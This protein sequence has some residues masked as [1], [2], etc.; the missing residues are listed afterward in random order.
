MTETSNQ[1]R[2]GL[3]ETVNERYPGSMITKQDNVKLASL[4]KPLSESKL[5]FVSSAGVQPIGT[6]PFDTVHPVGDYTY[7]KVP[8]GSKPEDLEIHQLKYPT[9][10][11]NEDLNVIFPIERL[12]ELSNEGKIGGLTENFFTFIGYNMDPD[13]LEQKLAEDIADAVVKDDADLALLCPA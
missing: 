10:G 9:V 11:A 6:M 7:R 5:T 1:M 13:Q 3:W 4:Y 2:P 12:Q 8:S